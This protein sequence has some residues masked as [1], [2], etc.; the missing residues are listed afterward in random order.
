MTNRKSSA[1]AWG[2]S[3]T[4]ASSTQNDLEK[5]IEILRSKLGSLYAIHVFRKCS[6]MQHGFPVLRP[7]WY[8]ALLFLTVPAQFACFMCAVQKHV[9]DLE[10]IGI[11]AG[12]GVID[13]A[14]FT[15]MCENIPRTLEQTNMMID[16]MD[17]LEMAGKLPE[18]DFSRLHA[19]PSQN[20]TCLQV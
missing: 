3:E 8:V 12:A 7:R 11:L 17:F 19:L 14:G 4:S 15:S 1:S 13:Q 18:I 10:A 5:V 6:P 20:A 16:Y 9:E 2:V